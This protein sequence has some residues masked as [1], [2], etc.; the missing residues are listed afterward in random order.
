MMAFC[1]FFATFTAG[2]VKWMAECTQSA[3][4]GVLRASKGVQKPLTPSV[5]GVWNGYYPAPGS[6]K[7]AFDH[8]H[9]AKKLHCRVQHTRFSDSK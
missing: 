5:L 4:G 2:P 3:V 7:V 6:G 1:G 9:V 8:I